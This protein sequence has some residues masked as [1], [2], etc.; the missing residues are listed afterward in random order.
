MIRT[1]ALQDFQRIPG[2]GIKVA[3]DLWDLGYRNTSDL[4]SQDPQAMYDR[5]CQIQ[6]TKVDRCML[7]VFRC[8][9]Y[10][11]TES[12]PNPDLLKWWRWKDQS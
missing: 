7:Y 3:Q 6:K 9:V 2:V 4:K 1:K 8:A 12:N 10:Y 11:A 5:L